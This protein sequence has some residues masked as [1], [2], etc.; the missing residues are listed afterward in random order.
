LPI[1][2]PRGAGLHILHEIDAAAPP[3]AGRLE[4]RGD[5]EALLRALEL[6]NRESQ[7][8]CSGSTGLDPGSAVQAEKVLCRALRSNL[9]EARDIPTLGLHA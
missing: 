6:E 7:E 1:R 5:P 2:R 8:T 9:P 3:A 4:P